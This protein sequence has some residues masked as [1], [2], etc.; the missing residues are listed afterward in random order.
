VP[1]GTTTAAIEAAAKGQAAHQKG[2]CDAR[3]AVITNNSAGPSQKR[4]VER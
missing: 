4:D 2:D 3:D 1:H